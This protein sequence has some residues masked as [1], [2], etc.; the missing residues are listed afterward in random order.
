[1]TVYWNPHNEVYPELALDQDF[2][3]FDEALEDS[4]GRVYLM[5][6]S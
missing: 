1:M 6:H 5:Q 3:A 4:I 2:I